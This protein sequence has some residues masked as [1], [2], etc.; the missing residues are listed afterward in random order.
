MLFFY[1]LSPHRLFVIL[2]IDHSPPTN[3]AAQQGLEPR[4]LGSEPSVLPLDD[5]ANVAFGCW[6]LAVSNERLT[7]YH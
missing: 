6:S 1:N 5:R 2:S 3:L 4:L 7:C